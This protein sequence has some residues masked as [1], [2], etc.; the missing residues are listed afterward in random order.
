MS[1]DRKPISVFF[2]LLLISVGVLLVLVNT[3]VITGSI[4]DNL[5]KFWP[6]IFLI[7]GLDGLFK[8]D[9]WAGPLVSIALGTILLL[10]NLNYLSMNAWGL[11]I[12]LWPVLLVAVGLDI[13]FGRRGS[14]WSSVVNVGLG[15][16]LAAGIVW[17]AL[18]S[19]LGVGARV[20]P[21]E[22]SLDGATKSEINISIPVGRLE[23][24]GGA[25]S[26]MLLSGSAAMPRN[27][28]FS[29]VYTK[30]Q[31][32]SSS[33]RLVSE[34]GVSMVTDAST[35]PWI[36]KLNSNLPID[37]VTKLAVGKM[38]SDLTL[39][40]VKDLGTEMAVGKS[41]VILPC[42][43][44]TKVNIK[45]AIGEVDIYLPAQ[46]T[47]NIH[48]ETGLVSVDLPANYIKT[49]DYARNQDAKPGSPTIDLEVG[50][51][52]GVVQIHEIP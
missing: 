20:I 38:D 7:G 46:C 41:K 50:V 14:T 18:V 40:R 15:L 4:W 45:L 3:G 6:V 1:G 17:I 22:Q 16:L 2:P 28:V 34:G 32:G 11:L 29:P 43:Q 42:T 31:N 51:A 9:G 12:R 21:F 10:G 48:L 27:M 44:D 19:P 33:L 24:A 37:L 36:F 5:Q 30:P 23:L 47:V 35:L 39:A 52:I 25:A 26:D 8:R 49:N 13:A